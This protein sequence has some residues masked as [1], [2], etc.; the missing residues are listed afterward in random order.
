MTP[1]CRTASWN[2]ALSFAQAEARRTE[3]RHSV[4]R[5]A[6]YWTADTYVGPCWAVMP[7]HSRYRPRR[8]RR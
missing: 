8:R 6:G 1:I 7:L 4:Q 5:L 3:R 2:Y